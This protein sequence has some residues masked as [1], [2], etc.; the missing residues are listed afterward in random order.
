MENGT[1]SSPHA[2]IMEGIAR[3]KLAALG[4]AQS[5][6]GDIESTENPENPDASESSSKIAWT[7][8]IEE[9]YDVD[10]IKADGWFLQS[11]PEERRNATR[12]IIEELRLPIA[13]LDQESKKATSVQVQSEKLDD[14]VRQEMTRISESQSPE[15]DEIMQVLWTAMV[16]NDRYVIGDTSYEAYA[17]EEFTAYSGAVLMNTANAVNQLVV[18]AEKNNQSVEP[19]Q[20]RQVLYT[21]LVQMR[22]LQSV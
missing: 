14:R 8:E 22:Y 12:S 5:G 4:A 16:K 21:M 1:A 7:N 9:Y 10:E 2:A 13:D 11:S 20:L 6:E 18:L 17:I 15:S 3:E 19:Q